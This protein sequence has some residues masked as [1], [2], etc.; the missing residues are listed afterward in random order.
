[1]GGCEPNRTC[2]YLPWRPAT[3]PSRPRKRL[4][5]AVTSARC[6]SASTRCALRWR[7]YTTSSRPSAQ[8]TRSQPS[9]QASPEANRGGASV[10]T[11]SLPSGPPLTQVPTVSGTWSGAGSGRGEGVP[12]G[13]RASRAAARAGASAGSISSSPMGMTRLASHGASVGAP[14]V[15][16]SSGLP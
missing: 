4:S 11:P 8:R 5:G 2:Q 10:T 6:P 13:R 7:S 1:M 12:G 14:T 9:G 15:R 16:A 3:T